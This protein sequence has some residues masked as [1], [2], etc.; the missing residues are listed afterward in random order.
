MKKIILVLLAVSLVFSVC[1]CNSESNPGEA[2]SSSTDTQ[3][4][5]SKDLSMFGGDDDY[6]IVYSSTAT[7]ALKEMI[8][9]MSENI[10]AVTG[11]TPKR[12]ADNA[13]ND[14]E[15]AREILIASTNRSQSDEVKSKISGIGY[16]VE[17]VGEKLVIMASNDMVLR[18]AVD[19]FMS[20]WS[21]SEGKITLPSTTVLTADLSE[22]MMTLCEN[23][24]FRYNIIIPT[25]LDES[26][27]SEVQALSSRL[28]TLTG[29]KVEINYDI[30]TT[31]SDDAYEICIGNTDRAI[32]QSLYA[33]LESMFDY[34]IRTVGNKIGVA[35]ES[36][37]ALQKAV[38]MLADELCTAMAN[39]YCGDVAIA[40]NY[41]L[42]GTTA[43]GLSDF[44]E[45]EK[46]TLKGTFSLGDSNERIYCYDNIIE[47]YYNDYIALL[48]NAK[49][50]VKN[51]YIM[52]ES[53]YTLLTHENYNVYVSY[54]AKTD[55]M[56]IVLDSTDSIY[57]EP[58]AP[59]TKNVC[60]PELWQLKL[61]NSEAGANGGMSYV[62]KL[63]DGTFVV[64]D[65]GYQ[66]D[67]P[68]L[69]EELKSNT[70]GDGKPVISAWIITHLHNDHYGA[71][72]GITNKYKD[73]VEVKAFYYNFPEI[74]CGDVGV[75]NTNDI[76]N[77]MRQWSGA[78][79]YGKLHSG[80]TF[81]VIDAKFTVICTY[82]DVFPQTIEN[83]NDTSTVLKAEVGGQSIMFLADAYYKESAVM[84]SQVDASVLKSDIVQI[85]HHGYEGCSEA[86]Y[87][88]VNASVAL[89]PMPIIGFKGNAV[90]KEWYE[91]SHNK[92]IRESEDIEKIF[93]SGENTIMLKLPYTPSG[94][95]ILDY[96]A[97]YALRTEE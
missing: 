35:A 69:Y 91:G 86:L 83:G 59:E 66:C 45:P 23:G 95:R 71:L 37:E 92:Y 29:K 11:S 82:E 39:T 28:S 70:E 94:D 78:T 65:G 24:T 81:S 79:M 13:K 80:M 77:Y 20:A 31:S 8:I 68:T 49:C 74:Q 57:P 4:V 2:D 16:R 43:E 62:I 60:T 56:R 89:W 90:F 33:E 36:A 6:R 63:T 53:K 44:P 87:R 72:K 64:I 50:T 12:V 76:I 97:Y 46:G 67:A 75:G 42:E 21:V 14:T 15:T 34:K 38:S 58:A 40:K 51:T 93:V 52:G 30:N 96:D 9:D 85:S 55:S 47:D 41:A 18:K 48:L 26:V 5:V 7:T 10:R 73:K 88:A 3:T 1:A 25:K 61:D 84:T 22:E 17:F 27:Y 19:A 32:S 54:I